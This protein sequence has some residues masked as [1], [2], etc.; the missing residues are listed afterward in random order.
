M[1]INNGIKQGEWFCAEYGIGIAEGFHDFYY[2][3]FSQIPRGKRI[4]DYEL[5]TV[6]YKLFCDYDG[7]P[8][9]RNRLKYENVR[10]CRPL[11]AKYEKI[12]NKSIK[13]H[14]KEYASFVKFLIVKK[15]IMECEWFSVSL[16]KNYEIK[17]IQDLEVIQKAL[18]P[19]F[20]YLDI[21]KVATDNQCVINMN[22][23]LEDTYYHPPKYIDIL[24][25]YYLG[26][27]VGKRLLFNKMSFSYNGRFYTDVTPLLDQMMADKYI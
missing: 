13:E 24:L 8:I 11:T 19:E 2:E 9:R 20:T 12:L 25:G 7:L 16:P 3:E 26:S 22:N 5:S 17:A 27:H 10:G 21:L 18:P 15:I 1:D 4:G 14:P 6:Q 23:I